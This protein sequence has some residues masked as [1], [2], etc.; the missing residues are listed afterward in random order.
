MALSNKGGDVND[1]FSPYIPTQNPSGT[2]GVSSYDDIAG[3]ELPLVDKLLDGLLIFGMIC[4]NASRD[5]PLFE[6]QKPH[7]KAFV[8]V[9]ITCWSIFAHR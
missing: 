6:L 5:A 2:I 9:D 1:F 8:E 7:Q 3:V 4:I